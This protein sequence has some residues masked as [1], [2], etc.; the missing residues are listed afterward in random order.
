MATYDIIQLT[1]AQYYLYP[2]ISDEGSRV[3]FSAMRGPSGMPTIWLYDKDHDDEPRQL[4]VFARGSDHALVCYHPQISGDGRKIVFTNQGYY[5]EAEK[6]GL[7]VY[8]IDSG[9]IQLKAENVIPRAPWG[10]EL[11]G[12]PGLEKQVCRKPA[13]SSDGRMLS[14]IV[15]Q[16]RYS[17]ATRDHWYP[18]QDILTI[19]E[20]GESPRGDDVLKIVR[21]NH[22]GNGILSQGI[23]GDG[24]SLAFYA[25]GTVDGLQVSNLEMPPYQTETHGEHSGPTCNVYCYIV[26]IENPPHYNLKV[27]PVPD[28][29]GQPLIVAHPQ[30]QELQ[31]FR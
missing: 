25:G 1:E 8:D 16:Y 30:S 3:V 23:S 27:V 24:R 5:T 29:P 18:H 22:F 12:E 20:R 19:A 7:Y 17:G 26:D 21:Q 13:I 28:S 11:P 15:T 31:S 6:S 4:S 2:S 14:F 10:L 9:T